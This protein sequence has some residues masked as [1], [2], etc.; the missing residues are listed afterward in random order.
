MI[1]TSA[2]SQNWK[3]NPVEPYAVCAQPLQVIP[4]WFWFYIAVYGDVGWAVATELRDAFI[5]VLEFSWKSCP[6][7]P[8]FHLSFGASFPFDCHR[9]E[10][11]SN[12]FSFSA[13]SPL[14]YKNMLCW[15]LVRSKE[16][17]GIKGYGYIDDIWYI[18]LCMAL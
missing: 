17:M 12:N 3:R 8:D 16:P 13:H 15:D 14:S 1:A 10:N 9:H 18:W 4:R 5:K 2:P 7:G 11:P 6:V